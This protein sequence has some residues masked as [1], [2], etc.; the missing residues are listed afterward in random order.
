MAEQTLFYAPLL[1]DELPRRAAG[2]SR[3]GEALA[4]NRK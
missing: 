3:R 1:Y 4:K 2:D